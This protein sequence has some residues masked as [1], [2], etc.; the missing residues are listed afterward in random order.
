VLV[1]RLCKP[2]F[3]NIKES[4]WQVLDM[5]E[6]ELP[7]L[8]QSSVADLST[9]PRPSFLL[10]RKRT[11]SDYDDEP[12]TSSDPATFS[13]DETAP[14]AE[15]Y[16]S[17]KRKKHTFRGSWWDKHPVKDGFRR[18][19]RKKR[20]WKR[21]FDSGIFMGSESEDPLSSDSFTMEDELLNDQKFAARP[22]ATF[23]SPIK[24]S[25]STPKG[26]VRVQQ[27][28]EEHQRV[29]DIVRQCLENGQ[30]DVDISY[31]VRSGHLCAKCTY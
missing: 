29:C 22:R 16:A 21:N 24:S 9:R 26:K 4:A 6:P 20:E 27:M 2:S 3:N 15:N 14:G 11:R 31:A 30:E 12:A 7:P 13:S 19:E 23:L 10:T 5:A 1:T 8:S 17:G 28:S 25:N 18:S